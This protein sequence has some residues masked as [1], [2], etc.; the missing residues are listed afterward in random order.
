MGRPET[1]RIKKKLSET[2]KGPHSNIIGIVIDTL[3]QKVVGIIFMMRLPASYQKIFLPTDGQLPLWAAL[4]FFFENQST[5]TIKF[6]FL[7]KK[8]LW[9]FLFQAWNSIKEH[10]N[11][12]SLEPD[13]KINDFHLQ[14]IDVPLMVHWWSIDFNSWPLNLKRKWW[15]NNRLESIEFGVT[16]FWEKKVSSFLYEYFSSFQRRFFQPNQ[17]RKTKRGKQTSRITFFVLDMILSVQ[18]TVVFAIV[19]RSLLKRVLFSE[20]IAVVNIASVI[21]LRRARLE[22]CDHVQSSIFGDL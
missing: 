16:L 2:P 18:K 14:I 15:M 10:T 9:T 13:V 8:S 11:A 6:W 21:W 1:F 4:R 20:K 7:N 22:L 17:S 12:V 3:R 5:C 19:W